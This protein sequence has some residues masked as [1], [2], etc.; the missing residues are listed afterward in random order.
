[1][2][3]G[4]FETHLRVSNLEASMRFYGETLALPFAHIDEKRRAAFYWIGGH[5]QAMLG[6]WEHPKEQIFRQ[7]FAFRVSLDNLHQ[8]VDWLKDRDLQP[9]NFFNDGTEHP[10]VFA[11]MP[12]LAIYFTDPDGH[13][14]EFIAPLSGTPQPEMGI[15]SWED[16]QGRNQG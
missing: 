2:I 1:M 4:L 6:L 14:L 10:M 12:A 7:H 9:R 11:W 13:S 16:W 3:D 15:V 5:N 8:S